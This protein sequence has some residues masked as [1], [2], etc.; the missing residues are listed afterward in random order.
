MVKAGGK[1]DA[2]ALLS[3]KQ[4]HLRKFVKQQV[5]VKQ[6]VKITVQHAENTVRQEMWPGARAVLLILS[7]MPSI[8]VPILSSGFRSPAF[9]GAETAWTEGSP[10]F[11]PAT[12]GC[13]FIDDGSPSA[14][15]HAAP[16]SSAVVGIVNAFA[17]LLNRYVLLVRDPIHQRSEEF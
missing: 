15:E 14:V 16:R 7:Q 1:V 5:F 3:K 11:A 6:H 2:A 12:G 13:D 4:L 9:V 10:R 8:F 17:I